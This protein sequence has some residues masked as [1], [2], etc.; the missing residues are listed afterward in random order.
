[1]YSISVNPLLQVVFSLQENYR[2]KQEASSLRRENTT[3]DSECHEKEKLL[4]QYKMRTAVL[5]QEV[6]DKEQVVL[7]T[8]DACESAQDH[9]VCVLLDYSLITQWKV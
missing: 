4:N 3:L 8:T 2:A 5:E 6:K 9:K 7:R 1:M